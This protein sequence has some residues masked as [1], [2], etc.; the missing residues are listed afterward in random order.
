M[1]F[2]REFKKQGP[3]I[4][5]DIIIYKGQKY[6]RDPNSSRRQH[7]VYYWKHDKWKEPPVSLH[8]QIYIDEVGP[9][10]EGYN[11]HHKDENTL[12]NELDN[13]ECLSQEEHRKRHPF[14][15]DV[16]LAATERAKKDKGKYLQAWREKYPEEAKEQ[17]IKNGKTSKGLENWRKTTPKEIQHEYQVKA[18]KA[19][20]K[21]AAIRKEKQAFGIS[22]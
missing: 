15:E 13:L 21:R 18:G 20:G 22:V 14:S 17:Y 7:R 12:N 11:I 6:Y 5:R 2:Q 4:L 8:R 1:E 16:M 19:N 9:I 3:F 10:P